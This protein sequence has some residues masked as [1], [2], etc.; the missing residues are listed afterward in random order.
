MVVGPISNVLDPSHSD[1]ILI[2]I[3]LFG[4]WLGLAGVMAA[5]RATFNYFAH[6]LWADD[7]TERWPPSI[8]GRAQIV[9]IMLLVFAGFGFLVAIAAAAFENP[10][11]SATG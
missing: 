7:K 3:I 1:W 10:G 8:S 2:G 6:N 5:W 11:S 9:L 4:A